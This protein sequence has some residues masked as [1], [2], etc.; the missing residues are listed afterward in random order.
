MTVESRDNTILGAHESSQDIP[1]YFGVNNWDS[2][3]DWITYKH[4]D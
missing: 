1:I 2:Y 3:I 4:H